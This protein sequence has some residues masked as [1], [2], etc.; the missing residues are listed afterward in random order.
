MKTV[1]NRS[2]DYFKDQKSLTD[3][4]LDCRAAAD[5]RQYPTLWR[6]RLLLSSRVWKPEKDTRVWQNRSGEMI[7][8]AMLW[9][10][11]A[12]SAYVVLDSYLH[13]TLAAKE[14]FVEILQWG[15]ARAHQ[16]AQ[17]QGSAITAYVTGAPQ[18]DFAVNILK[19]YGYAILPPNPTDDDVY[20]T[21]PLQDKILLPSL[22]SG[23]KIRKL[24]NVDELQAYQALSGFAY[25]L[26]RN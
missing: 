3:F 19:Q 2:C 8:F 10:R 12:T 4:W 1:T 14:L 22:P 20:F 24:Q 25:G 6:T 9:R 18:Q 17:E 7:G 16:I 15:D 11:Q 23:Y 21:K 13:P 5:V 26:C